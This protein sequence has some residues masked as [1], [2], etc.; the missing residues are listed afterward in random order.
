MHSTSTTQPIQK[1]DSPTDSGGTTDPGDQGDDFSTAVI[2]TPGTI[3]WL[4]P[5]AENDPLFGDGDDGTVPDESGPPATEDPDAVLSTDSG[6]ATDPGDQGDDYSAA[7][8][9]PGTID[10]LNPG[11][12]D[13]PL[14]DDSDTDWSSG[15]SVPDQP[16]GDVDGSSDSSTETG[17]SASTTPVSDSGPMA[18][19]D[20]QVD[21]DP[22]TGQP[23]TENADTGQTQPIQASGVDSTG[24]PLY[25]APT[26]AGGDTF[27]VDG[28]GAT[29]STLGPLDTSG[30]DSTPQE[31]TGAW[32]DTSGALTSGEPGSSGDD[33]GSYDDDTSGG[34]SGDDSSSY[35]G[36]SS[37]DDSSSYDDSS[38]GDDS[39]SFD[40]S[41][42]YDSSSVSEG[43]PVEEAPAVSDGGDDGGD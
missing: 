1:S 28:P 12:E 36:G 23:Y 40:D 43:A 25:Q 10:W 14:F 37:G 38:S 15:L 4:N 39:S 24:N 5:G 31:G 13:S 19:D 35:D 22:I 27:E 30:W 33:S 9:T 34:S 21:V 11:A 32:D 29:I 20:E 8:A 17:S 7:V 41:S 16:S 18:D 2:V 42:S 26:A 6:S 3:N